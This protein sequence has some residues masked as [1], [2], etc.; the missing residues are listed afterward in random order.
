LPQRLVKAQ[1]EDRL[2]EDLRQ[3]LRTEAKDHCL[4]RTGHSMNNAMAFADVSRELLLLQVHHADDVGYFSLYRRRL[5]G[6]WRLNNSD[7][8]KQMPPNPLDLRH[9]D[10]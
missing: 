2:D 7:F 9:G 10:T 6:Q 3:I 8:G 5:Q 4:A 1:D